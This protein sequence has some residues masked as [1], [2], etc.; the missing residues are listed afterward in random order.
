MQPHEFYAKYANT[1]LKN[2]FTILN[3]NEYGD[4]TLNKLF[5]EVRDLEDKIRPHQVQLDYLMKIA[6]KHLLTP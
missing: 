3:F 5:Q 1:Q 6:D 4:L 2:R